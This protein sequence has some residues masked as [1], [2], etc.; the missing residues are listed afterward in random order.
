MLLSREKIRSENIYESKLFFL[1]YRSFKVENIINKFLNER[2]IK[3][4]YDKL[5][6]NQ[7]YLNFY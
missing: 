1:F 6:L 7:N 5:I 4:C 3:K 2:L